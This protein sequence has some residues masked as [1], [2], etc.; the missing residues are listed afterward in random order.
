MQSYTYDAYG[1]IQSQSGTVRQPFT[2]TGRE[3]DTETGLYFYRA[4]MYDANVGRFTQ[5]DPIGFKG[6]DVNLRRYVDSVGKPLLDVNLYRYTG[7]DPIN[8][9]DPWGLDR[10]ES[11]IIYSDSGNIIGEYPLDDPHPLLDPVNWLSGFLTG[12]YKTGYEVVISR[13]CRIAPFGNR[14]GNPNGKLPHYHRR[15]VPGPDGQTPPGQGIG[16]HRPW[17]SSQHDGSW[18]DRF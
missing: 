4:R 16:R 6:G 7:N 9:I 2:F 11:G 14:T 5:K 12:W 18:R 13:N 10:V 17:D 3:F 8:Y 1:N 15:G